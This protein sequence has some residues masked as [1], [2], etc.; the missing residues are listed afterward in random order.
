MILCM[1]TNYTLDQNY[2]KLEQD[3]NNYITQT[4]YILFTGCMHL[5]V[6]VLHNPHKCCR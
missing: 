3:Y 1:I 5:V 2:S 4:V 6:T